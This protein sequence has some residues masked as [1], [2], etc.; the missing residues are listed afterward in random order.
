MS[1]LFVAFCYQKPHKSIFS[2][3][4]KCRELAHCKTSS[5]TPLGCP[6]TH[7]LATLFCWPIV[8]RLFVLRKNRCTDCAL[9]RVQGFEGGCF[10][11]CRSR[12]TRCNFHRVGES[13]TLMISLLLP[14]AN[15]NSALKAK[16]ALIKTFLGV[17][18]DHNIQGSSRQMQHKES[19]YLCFWES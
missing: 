6:L 1:H 12:S 17:K 5:T 11:I 9:G 3:F 16:H 8:N 2:P 15:Q 14:C 4:Q 13:V 10:V 7:S 18:F 19:T